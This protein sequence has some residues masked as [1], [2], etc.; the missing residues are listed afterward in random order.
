MPK[1]EL[2]PAQMQTYYHLNIYVKYCSYLKIISMSSNMIISIK[3]VLECVENNTWSNMYKHIIILEHG[4]SVISSSMFFLVELYSLKHQARLT[5]EMPI[6]NN[7]AVSMLFSW[8]S[9]LDQKNKST[10]FAI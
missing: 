8:K 7:W 9:T 10:E 2:Q 3:Y 6:E 5:I 1:D 4:D